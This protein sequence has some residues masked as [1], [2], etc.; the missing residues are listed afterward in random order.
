MLL[1]INFSYFSAL[2][3]SDTQASVMALDRKL[4]RV[5]PPWKKWRFVFSFTGH[6]SNI[7]NG[8]YQ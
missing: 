2:H 7:A 5:V 3:R 8:S 1:D 4:M 6:L